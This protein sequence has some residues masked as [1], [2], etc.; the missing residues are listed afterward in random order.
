MSTVI[1]NKTHGGFMAIDQEQVISLIKRGMTQSDVAK[2]YD[3]TRQYISLICKKNGLKYQKIIARKIKV[4]T[5]DHERNKIK[6]AANRLTTSAIKSGVLTRQ[7]CEVCGAFG[8]KN[9]RNVVDAHHDDYSKPL[10]VRWLCQKHHN[11][12]HKRP[13]DFENELK[14][15]NND[16]YLS[17]C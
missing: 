14:K 12:L 3:V 2:F 17:Q 11:M 9:G 10:D 5:Y 8:I 6:E 1:Y 7:P 4:K 15:K 16:L 13:L